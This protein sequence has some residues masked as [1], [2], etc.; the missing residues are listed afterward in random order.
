MVWIL[1]VGCVLCTPPSSVQLA[2]RSDISKLDCTGQKVDNLRNRWAY[3]ISCV[4]AHFKVEEQCNSVT[5]RFFA[6]YW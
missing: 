5:L 2:L 1:E 3:I 6:I 4:W